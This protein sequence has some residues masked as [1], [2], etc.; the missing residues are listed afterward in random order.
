MIGMRGYLRS[1]HDDRLSSE[2]GRA[3]AVQGGAVEAVVGVVE[4]HAATAAT[5]EQACAALHVL[6]TH[7]ACISVL[8]TCATRLA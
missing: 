4:R 5:V 3:R 6:C 7:R 1:T 8:A 2:T